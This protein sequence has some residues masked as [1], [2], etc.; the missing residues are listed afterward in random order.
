MLSS[1]LTTSARPIMQL[2][3][4]DYEPGAGAFDGVM[5]YVSQRLAMRRQSRVAAEVEV[6]AAPYAAPSYPPKHAHRHHHHQHRRR[7]S[8]QVGPHLLFC[9]F[10]MMLMV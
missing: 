8:Q 1:T 6:P 3:G 4:E 2:L 9:G 5:A 7:H 10:G